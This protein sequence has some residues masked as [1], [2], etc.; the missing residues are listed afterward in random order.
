M[1]ALE[2]NSGLQYRQDKPIP[3]VCGD[4]ALIRVK[5]AGICATD[6]ELVKGYAGFSGIIGHEFVGLVEAVGQEKHRHWLNK[7]VV[8][9]INIGCGDC[10]DCQ[11]DGPE[12]CSNRKV[13][14]IRGHDGAFADYLRLPVGNLFL[15]PDQVPDEEAVFTEPLAAAVRVLKQLAP[16]PVKPV[17]VIGPGRL[18]LLIA[19]VLGLAGYDVEVLGRSAN[20]LTLPKHWQLKAELILNVPA[21]HYDYVVDASG[22]ASGFSQALRIAK[23]RGTVVLK[24]TFAASE[25]LDLSKVVVGELHIL[26]SRCGPFDEALVL[27]QQGNVPVT[28]MVDGRY[29]LKDGEVALRRAAQPGVRKILLQP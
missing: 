11:S 29:S 28:T 26:G 3:A 14:G 25:P 19:K 9:S 16:L 18:G 1:Q 10:E 4:E 24:S 27:L 15:V 8:G 2:L 17:A 5:L 6:L 21:N 23:P 22:Q 20:S 13:L 12:H 7:R